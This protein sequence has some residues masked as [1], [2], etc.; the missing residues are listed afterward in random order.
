[1]T[2]LDGGML[3][4]QCTETAG[5]V[6]AL[7]HTQEFHKVSDVGLVFAN[8]TMNLSELDEPAYTTMYIH[9]MLL[10]THSNRFGFLYF[11]CV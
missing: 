10:A 1:M 7:P 2:Y 6:Y 4:A 3:V 11:K 9:T 5:P 8:P